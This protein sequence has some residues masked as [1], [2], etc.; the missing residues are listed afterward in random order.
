MGLILMTHFMPNDP[1]TPMKHCGKADIHRKGH[2]E[3]EAE[4]GEM[5]L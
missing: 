1:L 5:N 4:I 3:T 2:V